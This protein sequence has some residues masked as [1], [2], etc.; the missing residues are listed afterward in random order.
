MGRF[1]FPQV[2]VGDSHFSVDLKRVC[3]TKRLLLSLV[4]Y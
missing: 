2:K 3:K 1:F 4:G